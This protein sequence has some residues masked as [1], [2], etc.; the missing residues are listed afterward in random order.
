MSRTPQRVK[1]RSPTPSGAQVSPGDRAALNS[2]HRQELAASAID[3]AVISER[4]YQSV[5]RQDRAE[6]AALGIPAWALSSNERFPGL[7][8]PMYRATGE[9]ISVQFKPAT[10]ITIKGKG[11][12]YVS[13][14]G[15]TNRL[16]VHPRNHSRITDLT[17][18]LWIT[19]GVKKGDSLTSRG[20]CTV[21]I[22]GVFGWRSK[23]ATL[24]DWEDV[25][26]KGREIF[27]CFDADARTNRNVAR[28]MVRFGR[29]CSSKGAKGVRYLIVPNE[30]RGTVTKG[31]DDYFAAGGTLEA[32]VAFATTTEPDVETADDT[33]T[34]ARL[35]ETFSD[36]V[37]ADRFLWCKALGW[38]GWSGQRWISVT[39]EAVGEAIRQYLLRRF[40]EAVEAG[41]KAAIHGWLSML[42]ANRQRAVLSLA[43]GIVERTAD[44]FDADPDLLNTPAGVVHLQSGQV[45]PH[46]PDFLVTKITSGSYQPG[47][48]HLDW[49]QALTALPEELRAWF[50]VRAGQA[51]TGH[52]TPD[53]IIPIMQGGGENGKS[54][55]TTDGIVPALGDYAAP[56]SPKL[57][58]S[59]KEEHSTERADLRGQRF[60]IA[61]ELTEDR[62][63]NVT[64]IKQITDVSLIRARHV[65]R[66]NFTFQA[67][68]SLFVT[69]NYIPVINETDHGT[70]RR[71]ALVKF[72]FTF[73]KP[74]EA[75]TAPTDRRG[76]PGLKTR[77]RAGVNGQ[78]DA[79]VTWV[80]EGARRWYAS[81]FPALPA[82][83]E[84][85][86]RAWRTQADRILGFWDEML[87][88]DRGACVLTT[89]LLQ[90]FNT[91][92]KDNGHREWSKEIFHPRFKSHVETV[93]HHVEERRTM[94]LE[95][96]SRPSETASQ[97]TPRQALLYLGVRFLA[98]SDVDENLKRNS[99][100]A[101]VAD[102]PGTSTREGSIAKVPDRSARCASVDSPTCRAGGARSSSDVS[103]ALRGPS[104]GSGA[105][106]RS[107]P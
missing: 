18:P 85:D 22:T 28:A 6:V 51:I 99:K 90:V 42:T 12:K 103:S 27:V 59:G 102:L 54:A 79:I 66:D 1:R 21:T 73:R 69:T 71:L 65:F 17:V 14:R 52:P 93:R 4:G 97:P 89:E 96:L 36:E 23:L 87:I 83:V 20:C 86:T 32:L 53:G 29:W 56:V 55:L 5:E 10:P 48:T 11:L 43:K 8:V 106:R 98:P 63:L 92:L 70:W 100:V 19:E 40:T 62:A 46:D 45:Q 80:V 84:T 2:I 94:K 60:L 25:P 105:S 31:V 104:T 37:L 57:I 3:E 64:A 68:H 88:A 39:E 82:T 9:R 30:T 7:L 78:H 76:D 67:S 72:P 24:G 15:Q 58:A 34:D 26:L 16:D 91:W 107:P 13:V 75:L 38:R 33:F 50:Q 74:H 81:G 41:K 35:A 49:D 61:E 47:Y 101:E 95:G 44:E 77:L